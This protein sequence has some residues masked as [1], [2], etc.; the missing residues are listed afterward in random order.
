MLF[1]LGGFH[2]LPQP[3][4]QPESHILCKN[5]GDLNSEVESGISAVMVSAE[6]CGVAEILLN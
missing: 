1:C 2:K 6:Q 5:P 3:G 4:G